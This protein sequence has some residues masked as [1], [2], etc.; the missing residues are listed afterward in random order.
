MGDSMRD[1]H[2][3]VGATLSVTQTI[4]LFTV[5]MPPITDI[6]HHNG[7]SSH[8][9]ATDVRQAELVAGTLSLSVAAIMARIEDSWTPF[10]A[11]SILVAV[12]IGSYEYTLRKPGYSAPLVNI[13]TNSERSQG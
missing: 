7:D 13:T 9:F 8:P 4:S 5:L 11:T 10:I 3:M 2:G 6:H 12:L 1:G